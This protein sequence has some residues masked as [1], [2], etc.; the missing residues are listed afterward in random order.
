MGGKIG[1]FGEEENPKR[2]K[3]GGKFLHGGIEVNLK[4][5]LKKVAK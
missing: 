4:K 2:S 3:I 5:A 1:L